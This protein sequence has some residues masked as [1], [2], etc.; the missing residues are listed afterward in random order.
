MIV[1]YQMVAVNISA[2][3]TKPAITTANV[4]VDTCSDLITSRV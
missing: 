1:P 4:Q 3:A 2:S